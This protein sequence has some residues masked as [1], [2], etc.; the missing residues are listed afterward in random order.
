MLAGQIEQLVSMSLKGW[1]TLTVSG[2]EEAVIR[3]EANIRADKAQARLTE[4]LK[5]QSKN[6]QQMLERMI[7]GRDNALVAEV[8]GYIQDICFTGKREREWAERQAEAQRR[9]EAFAN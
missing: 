1:M 3:K 7:G 5:R 6:S 8:F 4:I 9:L 2:R